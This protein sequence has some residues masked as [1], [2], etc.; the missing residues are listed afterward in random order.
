[1]NLKL[2]RVQQINKID[3]Q[4]SQ[5]MKQEMKQDSSVETDP[6]EAKNIE[7]VSP[8]EYCKNIID[9]FE[10]SNYSYTESLPEP[11][12]MKVDPEEQFQKCVDEANNEPEK[13]P[14]F[15]NECAL[16]SNNM[17]NFENC[18]IGG[19]IKNSCSIM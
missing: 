1:M 16:Q 6:I 15:V 5:E 17:S 7:R 11:D 18:V 2:I 19:T 9:L 12:F 10:R 13:P 8:E 4:T 14:K 3:E